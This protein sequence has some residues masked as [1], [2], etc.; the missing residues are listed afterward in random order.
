MI[1]HQHDLVRP[2]DSTARFRILDIVHAWAY[3][4]RVT[5]SNQSFDHRAQPHHV[6]IERLLHVCAA[7]GGEHHIQRCPILRMGVMK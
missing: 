5:Q 7:C 3:I 6:R 1:F 2:I 4:R